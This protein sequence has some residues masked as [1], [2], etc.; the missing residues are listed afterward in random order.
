MATP[1]KKPLAILT[2]DALLAADDLKTEV[3]NVPEWGG[4]VKVR[5]LKKGEWDK[6]QAEDDEVKGNSFLLSCG[7][8]EPELTPEQVDQLREK[9]LLAVNK[10]ET[11]I[12]RC[13][14]MDLGGLEAA[15][16]SFL[17]GDAS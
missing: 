1:R 7:I 5:G 6:A 15:E 16:K 11:A 3:V 9:S 13:S 2:A 10:L 17:A 8:L 12:I 4:A 14:G